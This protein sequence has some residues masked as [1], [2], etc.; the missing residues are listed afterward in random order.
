MYHPLLDDKGHPAEYHAQLDFNLTSCQDL[1]DVNAAVVKSAVA[2][3]T[4]A[5]RKGREHSA[6]IKALFAERNCQE[7]AEERKRLS[8]LLWRKLREQTRQRQEEDFQALIARGAGLQKL[9]TLTENHSGAKSICRMKNEDG[10]AVTNMEDICEVVARFYEKLYAAYR[11]QEAGNEER[12]PTRVPK[13]TTEEQK[14]ALRRLRT[15]RASG[16]DGLTAEML[17]TGHEP[18]LVH[19]SEMFSGILGG[20]LDPP[21]AWKVSRLSL[22]FKNGERDLPKNYRPV[23]IIPIMSKL[24]CVVLY[25]R[26][27]DQ[28]EAK[29]TPEQ[30]GFV[31]GRGCRD[32]LHILRAVTEKAGEWGEELWVATLDAEK[33]F[34]KVSHDALFGALLE[35]EVDFYAI[36]CLRRLYAGLEA[37]VK[38]APGCESRAFRIA[39]GVRQG[40]PLS[41]MLFNMLIGQVL[42]KVEVTWKRRGYGT[43]IG[44][45]LTGERLTHVTFA[46]DITLVGQTWIQIKRM[47]LD[48]RVALQECGL[49]LHPSKCKVQTNVAEHVARGDVHLTSTFSVHIL[50]AGACLTVLG[51]VLS[52]DDVTRNEISARISAGW[53]KFWAL[54]RLLLNQ[55]ASLRRRLQLFDATV[56]ACVLW[57]AQSWT[58]RAEE[59]RQLNTAQNAMLRRIVG[60]RRSDVEDYVSWLRRATGNARR[61]ASEMGVKN[62]VST[63]AQMKWEWAGKVARQS[64]NSWVYKTVFWRDAE[65]NEV[66]TMTLGSARPMRPSKQRRMKWEDSLRRFSKSRGLGTWRALAIDPCIWESWTA[67][68]VKWIV[69]SSR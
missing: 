45:A 33:A 58:P 17:Q 2:S 8:K 56:G 7:D 24:F 59:L 21:A 19:M 66:A 52:L 22:I 16:N 27:R 10:E 5:S 30:F 13:V 39:R 60:T 54:Q 35:G 26:L 42:R 62:W 44:R 46:D 18:L 55:K 69:G 9:K 11:P 63:F 23:S 57:A 48:L 40:D 12:Q 29:T 31:R 67:D 36:A 14:T 6:E 50:P 25:L 4:H 53:R 61:V 68:Y 37:Y 51:T 41:P 47:I 32:A 15:N 38:V 28:M 49:S 1:T 34:D 20:D 43:R 3:A 65:W 64:P